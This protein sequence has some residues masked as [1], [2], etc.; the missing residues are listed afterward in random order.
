MI[1]IDILC[2]N[3]T[4]YILRTDIMFKKVEPTIND[5]DEE[6][7]LQLIEQAERHEV[8]SCYTPSPKH[9]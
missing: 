2:R 7:A 5:A 1:S 6:I 4:K 9:Q 8:T 3:G